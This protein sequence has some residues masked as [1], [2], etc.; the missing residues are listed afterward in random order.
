MQPVQWFFK[1]I[2]AGMMISIGGVVL[3]ETTAQCGQEFKWVG[4]ILFSVGLY[5]VVLYGLNLYTGKVRLYKAGAAPTILRRDG[6]GILVESTSLPAGIL[7]GVEFEESSF[8]LEEGDLLL[9]LSDGA[10]A[11]GCQWLL[12]ELEAFRQE[13][14]DSLCQR[15]ART[16]R[17]RRTDGR[18]DDITILC[19]RL[20]RQL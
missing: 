16:A 7:E 17:L 9:L 14:L 6:K 15:L 12:R 10:S 11:Q 4:A 19:C 2:L 20:T 8:T 1:A 18:E 5:A 13:D 3:L